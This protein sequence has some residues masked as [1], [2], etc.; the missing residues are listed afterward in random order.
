M[1]DVAS[2]VGMTTSQS[3]AKHLKTIADLNEKLKATELKLETNSKRISM[4]QKEITSINELIYRTQEGK[5]RIEYK[6]QRLWT[7]C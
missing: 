5:Y 6:P 2:G 1:F 3:V 7:S 4:S